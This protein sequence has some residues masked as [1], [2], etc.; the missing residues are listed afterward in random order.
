M[1]AGRKNGFE[2]VLEKGLVHRAGGGAGAVL[3]RCGRGHRH[4]LASPALALTLSP[5]ASRRLDRDQIE[6]LS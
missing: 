4:V 6:D 2:G 1:G 3:D 5:G